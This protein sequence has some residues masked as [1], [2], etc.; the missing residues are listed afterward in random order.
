MKMSGMRGAW[1]LTGNFV[2]LTILNFTDLGI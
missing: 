1:Y 2:K